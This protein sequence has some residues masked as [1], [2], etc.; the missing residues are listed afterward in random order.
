[1]M[2]IK[3]TRTYFELIVSAK[4]SVLHSVSSKVLQDQNNHENRH[5]KL[6]DIFLDNLTG[7]LMTFRANLSV[8]IFET[9]LTTR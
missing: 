1:M 2:A 4:K 3:L 9:N 5:A 8:L 6:A 7:G